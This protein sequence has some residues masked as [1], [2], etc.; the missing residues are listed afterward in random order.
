MTLDRVGSAE[1]PDLA[2]LAA[3]RAIAPRA[4][5][6]GAGGVRDLADLRAA[7]AAGAT[8][9]LLAS[10]LHDGRIA[11]SELRMLATQCAESEA[12][13]AAAATQCRVGP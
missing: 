2:S 5:L 1:G 8:G 13:G 6:I 11:A 7:A 3:V 10:A 4:A 12:V 9:W